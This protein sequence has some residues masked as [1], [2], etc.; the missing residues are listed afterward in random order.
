MERR[1]IFSNYSNSHDVLNWPGVLI[2]VENF[3]TVMES[4]SG[5]RTKSR[6]YRKWTYM[7]ISQCKFPHKNNEMKWYEINKYIY[8]R[9]RCIWIHWLPLHRLH[10]ENT[11]D[12]HNNQRLAHTD[13]RQNRHCTHRGSC[14]QNNIRISR[15]SSE[16]VGIMTFYNMLG[17]QEYKQAQEL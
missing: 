1:V 13:Y 5:S 2:E 16:A 17:T 8:L 6:R 14:G 3:W 10:L 12:F 7:Q 15:L 4:T 9:G 11:V